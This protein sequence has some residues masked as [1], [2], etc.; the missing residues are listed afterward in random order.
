MKNSSRILATICGLLLGFSFTFVPRAAQAGTITVDTVADLVDGDVSSIAN[1]IAT[2]G[3]DGKISLREAISAANNTVGADII[4][5]DSSTNGS[6]LTLTGAS[7]EDANVSG[8]LDIIGSDDLTITGNG[9]A[10]TIIQAG[11][12]TTNGIDRVFDIIFNTGSDVTFE[13]L[14]IRHGRIFGPDGGGIQA[15]G[16][17]VTVT[18]STISD[19]TAGDGGAIRSLGGAV[20]V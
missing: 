13:N 8:D 3:T 7:G 11:T 16:R 14:T 12:T 1:L 10:N 19:N 4:L 15:L 2:P 6:P 20:T 5:F 17:S 18:N 9:I